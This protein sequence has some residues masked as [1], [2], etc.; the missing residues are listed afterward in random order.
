MP[1]HNDESESRPY[2]SFCGKGPDAV[3]KLIE[4]SH[5]YI[6]D[7]CVNLCANI[8]KS[9]DSPSNSAPPGAGP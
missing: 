3:R 6:C 5:A 1:G 9:E 8:L 7:E 4:G 2:C